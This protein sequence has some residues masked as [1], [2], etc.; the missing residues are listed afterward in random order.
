MPKFNYTKF[1][2]AFTEKRFKTAYEKKQAMTVRVL[3]KE[4]GISAA[5]V[6]RFANGSRID[7]DSIL[8]VC[9]WLKIEIGEFIK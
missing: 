8:K 2:K 5:T 6:N 7:I 4:I 9:H 1:N 3:A